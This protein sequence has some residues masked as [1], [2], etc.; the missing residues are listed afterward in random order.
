LL[1]S[2]AN[3]HLGLVSVRSNRDFAL[4][5]FNVEPGMVYRVRIIAAMFMTA[6]YTAF[7]I[8]KHTFQVQYKYPFK[9]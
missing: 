2:L 3:G 6:G 7:A 8:E 5:T 1:L 9:C 4:Q